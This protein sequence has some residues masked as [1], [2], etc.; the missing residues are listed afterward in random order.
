MT[1]HENLLMGAYTLRDKAVIA[2]RLDKVY[3]LFPWLKERAGEKAGN[4]SGGQQKVLEIGRALML[5]P[6]LLILDEPSLG[7]HLRPWQACLKQFRE[8]N[9]A[10]LTILMVEQNA[11]EG[12]ASAHRGYVL[13]L[14]RDKFEGIA[15][16]LLDSPE[17]A[18]LYLEVTD[19]EIYRRRNRQPT[20]QPP[21][22]P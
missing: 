3:A 14:G 18:K 16:E 8:L 11:R 4:L 1:L 9:S 12:L 17:M 20:V 13:E 2:Q 22:A 6:P 5:E 10:G 19:G 21:T 7:S 15:K